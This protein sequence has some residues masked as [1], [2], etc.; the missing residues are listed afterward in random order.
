MSPARVAGDVSGEVDFATV[1]YFCCYDISGEV[2]DEVSGE[3]SVRRL[4]FLFCF[5]IVFCYNSIIFLLLRNVICTHCS[6]CGIWKLKVGHVSIRGP[7]GWK[8]PIP[9]GTLSTLPIKCL[10]YYVI[11]V[12]TP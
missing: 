8:P 6:N 11:L 3:F 9:R 5:R 1:A 4:F 12:Y 7:G 10:R 2:S